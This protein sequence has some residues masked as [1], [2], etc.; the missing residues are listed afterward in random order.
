MSPSCIIHQGAITAA[1][2]TVYPTRPCVLSTPREVSMTLLP[3]GTLS[4]PT[5]APQPA[6]INVCT[7]ADRWVVSG[8][9]WLEWEEWGRMTGERK[10]PGK[11]QLAG[12]SSGALYLTLL[13]F[14]WAWRTKT[15]LCCIQIFIVSSPF[16][17]PCCPFM[18]DQF[19]L[20][21]PPLSVLM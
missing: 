3:D 14:T 4:A 1:D 16:K 2:R 20:L 8:R 7:L 5:V 17:I 13:W 6:V 12:S 9:L 21:A 19:C 18:N 15:L 11:A 10:A